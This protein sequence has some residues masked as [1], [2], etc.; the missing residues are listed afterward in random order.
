MLNLYRYHATPDALTGYKENPPMKVTVAA[1]L[2]SMKGIGEQLHTMST[3]DPST[4]NPPYDVLCKYADDFE[5]SQT[6]YD[7]INIQIKN[8]TGEIIVTDQVVKGYVND[9]RVADVLTMDLSLN[10]TIAGNDV[11]LHKFQEQLLQYMADAL[12]RK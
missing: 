1:L 7:T 8:V 9:V 11:H 10:D 6:E 12:G 2:Q 5:Y 4:I 3:Y